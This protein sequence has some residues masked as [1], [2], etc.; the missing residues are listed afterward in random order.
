MWHALA[1][2]LEMGVSA[3][4]REAVEEKRAA[5]IAQGKKP[6]RK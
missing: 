4:V 6:P 3:M 1:R 5:L 2:Y